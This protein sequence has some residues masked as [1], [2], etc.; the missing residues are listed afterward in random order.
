MTYTDNEGTIIAAYAIGC[1]HGIIYA[2][3]EYPLAVANGKEAID[4]AFEEGVAAAMAIK[5]HRENRTIFWDKDN[6]KVV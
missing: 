3:A 2:R 5:A 1:A 4:Q 6:E